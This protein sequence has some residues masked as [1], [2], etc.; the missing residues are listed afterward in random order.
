MKTIRLEFNPNDI[1]T[2]LGELTKA[3]NGNPGTKI[4]SYESGKVTTDENSL[5]YFQAVLEN[6]SGDEALTQCQ[7][8]VAELKAKIAKAEDDLTTE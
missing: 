4:I 2:V 1:Q 8:E 5:Y 6:I 3:W 7:A